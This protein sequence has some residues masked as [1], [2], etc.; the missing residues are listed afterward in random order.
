[1]KAKIEVID[2]S[3]IEIEL[4]NIRLAK[5]SGV[6]LFNGYFG[7]SFMEDGFF[8]YS[9]EV[10]LYCEDRKENLI[11]GLTHELTEMTI[12][13]LILEFGY[14]GE[15]VFVGDYIDLKIYFKIDHLVTVLSLPYYGIHLLHVS[16]Y[17]AMLK[18]HKKPSKIEAKRKGL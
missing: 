13:K 11:E 8:N 17:E 12:K 4:D 14:I 6:K 3:K 16:N 7:F 2:T 18:T 15:R 1:M 5:S 10:T 9:S